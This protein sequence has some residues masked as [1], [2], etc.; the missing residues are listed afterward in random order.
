ME[1]K[2][3]WN[4]TLPEP[5]HLGVMQMPRSL[6]ANKVLDAPQRDGFIGLRRPQVPAWKAKSRRFNSSDEDEDA[7][8]DD[9]ASMA[10]CSLKMDILSNH[11]CIEALSG[12]DSEDGGGQMGIEEKFF[13]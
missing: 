4:P 7:A 11:A 13:C 5:S 6:I 9:D 12:V 3:R 2:G 10:G 8:A 1:V